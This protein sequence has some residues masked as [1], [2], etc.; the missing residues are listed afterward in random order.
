MTK[1]AKEVEQA[2]ASAAATIE[3][4]AQ[5]PLN[6]ATAAAQL[7]DRSASGDVDDSTHMSESAHSKLQTADQTTEQGAGRINFRFITAR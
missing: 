5:V 4:Y 3:Q 2:L 1:K 7:E 6:D